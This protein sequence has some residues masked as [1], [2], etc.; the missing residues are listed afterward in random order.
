MPKPANLTEK[1]WD[2][3]KCAFLDLCGTA[4]ARVALDILIIDPEAV[5]DTLNELLQ[6]FPELEDEAPASL[7]DTL[8]AIDSL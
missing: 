4:E 3:L 7:D 5:R 2:A 8:E 1:Q 6:A